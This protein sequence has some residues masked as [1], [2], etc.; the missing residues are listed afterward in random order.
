MPRNILD[1]IV[2]DKRD[3]LRQRQQ[4]TPLASL[5]ARCRDLPPAR[6]F[7][8]ALRPRATG[9]RL[10]AEVKKASPSRGTLAP[11]LDPVALAT[12]Y[13][14]HGADAISVLTDE[15]YF[16]GHLDLLD[17]IRG[18]V[19]VP[20]LR[21]D[22]T[23]AEYQLWESRAAGA[24]AVLLIVSILEASELRDLLQAA[25]GVGLAALVECHTVGE[26]ETALAVG[27]RVVGINNRDL[28]TFNT[29]IETTLELLPRIPPGHIVVSES[30]F[31][32]GDQVKRVAVAGAHAV[33]VGEALVTA[34]DVPAKIRELKDART[35]G[36]MGVRSQPAQTLGAVDAPSHSAPATGAVDAPSHPGQ[37]GGEMG[38]ASRPPH[39]S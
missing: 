3:E 19:P 1:D 16:H 13:A 7:E 24:D 32:T 20:L 25:K 18:A 27:A 36:E 2:R 5:E 34:S 12:T 4:A 6:D 22:F 10:I 9:V 14:R 17:A 31:F 8:E 35:G 38:G 28:T 26:L 15:K 39:C 23:L 30:G 29:R 33:L 11:T 21:K 37:T